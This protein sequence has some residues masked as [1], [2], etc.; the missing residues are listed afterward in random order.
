[1]NAAPACIAAGCIKEMSF[2]LVNTP[3]EIIDSAMFLFDLF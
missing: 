1:M 2:S 3:G